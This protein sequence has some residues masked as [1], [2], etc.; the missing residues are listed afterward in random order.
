VSLQNAL[1]YHKA[2]EVNTGRSIILY[3]W[4]LVNIW[5]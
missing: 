2:V 1:V 5:S 3:E 4:Y